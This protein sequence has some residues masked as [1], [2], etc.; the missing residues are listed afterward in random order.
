MSKHIKLEDVKEAFTEKVIISSRE[1]AEELTRVLRAIKQRIADLP[2]IDIV[3]CKDCK[4][5]PKKTQNFM[6]GKCPFCCEDV[7]Y[8]STP[9]DDFYCAYGERIDNE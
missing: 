7:W 2:T 5:N 8:S 6:D 4:H 9:S 1:S 3:H